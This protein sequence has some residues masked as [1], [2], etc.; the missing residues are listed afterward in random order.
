MSVAQ[1]HITKESMALVSTGSFAVN[2]ANYRSLLLSYEKELQSSPVDEK[3]SA[4]IFKELSM[5]QEIIGEQIRIAGPNARQLGVPPEDLKELETIYGRA[6]GLS[7]INYAT[8]YEFIFDSSFDDYLAYVEKWPDATELHRNFAA[9]IQMA[10]MTMTQLFRAPNAAS[11][12]SM[13]FVGLMSRLSEMRLQVI[14]SMPSGIV[15]G[16]GGPPKRPPTAPVVAPGSGGEDNQKM[17]QRVSNVEF[18]LGHLQKDVTEI[19]SDVKEM[20]RDIKA[21][22]ADVRSDIRADFR[23]GMGA[24]ITVAL[25]LAGL[26]A[27]AFHWF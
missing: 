21:D 19:K 20:R 27:K 22:F 2:V 6:F 26:M 1:D 4:L 5:L 3:R 24:V 10:R 7:A 15:I 16:A 18:A 13:A 17:E 9:T 8:K 23:L 11:L 12:I 25:G 14:E